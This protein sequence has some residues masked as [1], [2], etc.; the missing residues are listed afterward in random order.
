ML[1]NRM[2]QFKHQSLATSMQD[3]AKMMQTRS[4]LRH[5]P[6]DLFKSIV[7]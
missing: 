1:Q 5:V 6:G 7:F 3:D 4:G 2:Q